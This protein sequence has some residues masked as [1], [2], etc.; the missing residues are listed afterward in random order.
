MAILI[1][2]LKR[3]ALTRLLRR[4]AECG[5]ECSLT[6]EVRSEGERSRPREDCTGNRQDAIAELPDSDPDLPYRTG[7]WTMSTHVF[8]GGAAISAIVATWLFYRFLA[9]QNWH[10]WSRAGLVQAFIIAFYAEMY[11]FP[12]TIYL[13][14][15]L[16]G[17]DLPA[18]FWDGNFW[19][20]L[21]G[22][23]TAMI[24]SMIVGYTIV[25]LGGALLVA[26][27]RELHR[28]SR[29]G[30]LA[31]RG[32]YSFVRHPQYD[33]L[34]LAIFGEGV[35]HW[36]TLFSVT[37]FPVIVTAYVFLALKE[38]R[39]MLG[40]FGESYREYQRRVPMFVPGRRA[41]LEILGAR[42]SSRRHDRDRT[43]GAIES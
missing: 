14:G 29:Q 9:P 21:T 3:A 20:Y 31:S 28:A 24:V 6:F 38:E 25:V 32:P 37:A 15:R 19:I 30:R 11:G 42:P 8:W 1:A 40:Q 7:R 17:L 12:L 10:E 41:W 18:T 23:P 2:V 22:N 39:Q 27:W 36:P 33:G 4:L 13:A 43:Q 35:V 26:G 16:F 34:F 5:W